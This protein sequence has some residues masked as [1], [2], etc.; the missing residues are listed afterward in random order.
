MEPNP[1]Q[2]TL[3]R[4]IAVPARRRII[5]VTAAQLPARPRP[6][7][8]PYSHARRRHGLRIGAYFY[9]QTIADRDLSRLPDGACF[10]WNET[11]EV[12]R[13]R[14]RFDGHDQP[15]T[16]TIDD[17]T[18][19]EWD[20]TDPDAMHQQV[21]LAQAHGVDF[22]VFDSYIGT[23]N[24]I[25]VREMT[26]PV[27][28]FLQNPGSMRFALM[29]VLE[30]PRVRLPFS[31]HA[32]PEHGRPYDICE[33]TALAIRDEARRRWQHPSYVT[34]AGR[35]VVLVMANSHQ[36]ASPQMPRLLAVLRETQEPRPFVILILRRISDLPLIHSLA[37]DAVTG[38]AYLPDFSSGA[39]PLQSYPDRVEQVG[40]EWEWIQAHLPVPF[41]PPAVCGWDATPRGD[42]D[43]AWET[44]SA[45]SIYPHVP[46]LHGSTPEAFARMLDRAAA[47][48]ASHTRNPW[49]DDGLVLVTAWNEIGEGCALLPRVLPGNPC[50]TG[51]LE[52]LTEK[53][54]DS[55]ATQHPSTS[56]ASSP[57]TPHFPTDT[58]S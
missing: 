19:M 46:V 3:P 43:M 44:A 47:F 10:H 51:F 54:G 8:A 55:P 6:E 29:F 48:T 13:A 39:E 26:A 18:T 30:S 58:R 35:P 16:Y 27:D 7:C 36:L 12:G 34:L 11:R 42:R 28:A 45:H 24:R 57:S 1:N 4:H 17:G 52:A 22:F 56:T 40:R 49:R 50:D 33:A 38:Y 15:R 31:A 41:L 2:A 9:P 5:P 25:P 20:D 14:P 53:D 21:R 37:P 32:E 23:R